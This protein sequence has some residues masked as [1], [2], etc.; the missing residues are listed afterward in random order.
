MFT[1][2]PK[3]SG[4]FRYEEHEAPR[5][6]SEILQVFCLE[7][8][9]FSE[10]EMVAITACL[11][12]L[13]LNGWRLYSTQQSMTLAGFPCFRYFHFVFEAVLPNRSNQVLPRS[14]P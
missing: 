11:N 3:S 1:T 12:A 10:L 2:K 4:G 14:R 6:P 7:F 5:S 13:I 8:L 9:L